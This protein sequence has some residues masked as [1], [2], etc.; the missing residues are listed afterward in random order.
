M[1]LGGWGCSCVA[2]RGGEYLVYTNNISTQSDKDTGNV[3]KGGGIVSDQPTGR[4]RCGA[5]R[6]TFHIR[7]VLHIWDW[8][9]R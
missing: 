6:I 9:I 5:E 2:R 7:S 4:C 1:S 3:R 8:V